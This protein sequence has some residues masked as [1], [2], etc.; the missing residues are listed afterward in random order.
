MASR[1]LR[2]VLLRR[3]AVNDLP[4]EVYYRLAQC[5][6]VM[7][8]YGCVCCEAWQRTNA[9]LMRVFAIYED[10]PALW[11]D[12]NPIPIL[13]EAKTEYAKLH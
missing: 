2:T 1:G 4:T 7:G 10:F 9:A 12:A 6:V 8:H 11:K 3:S 5:G 13:K